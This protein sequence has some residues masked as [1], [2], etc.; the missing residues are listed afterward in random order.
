MRRSI[1]VCQA[2]VFLILILDAVAA[3]LVIFHLSQA[4]VFKVRVLD[5]IAI[6]KPI[7]G[8]S[9]ALILHVRITNGIAFTRL[10]QIRSGEKRHQRTHQQSIY[11]GLYSL[12]AFKT[13]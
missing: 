11:H 10:R 5:R 2:A 1:K 4:T 6:G 8:D 3:G 13:T 7:L 12:E 9:Q